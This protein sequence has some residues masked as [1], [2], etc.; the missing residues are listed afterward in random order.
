[1]TIEAI[2]ALAFEQTTIH[3]AVL[4]IVKLFDGAGEAVDKLGRDGEASRDR[5]IELV[6]EE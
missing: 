1:M 4:Q 2:E 3:D 6:T 5:I